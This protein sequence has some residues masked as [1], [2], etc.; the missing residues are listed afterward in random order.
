MREVRGRC[1]DSGDGGGDD[2]SG[3]GGGSEGGV[4]GAEGGV[5]CTCNDDGQAGTELH[6][7]EHSV[8]V[9][10]EGIEEQPEEVSRAGGHLHSVQRPAELLESD[11]GATSLGRV[12][13][14]L[15]EGSLHVPQLILAEVHRLGHLAQRE[16]VRPTQGCSIRGEGGPHCS[17][18]VPHL[19][20][21][22]ALGA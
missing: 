5:S 19:T 9:L 22:Q 7:V 2:S 1:G 8:A 20:A 13:G 18:G 11:H 16:V 4:G 6:V 10:V 12:G 14:D 15:H 3:K 21:K 17:R